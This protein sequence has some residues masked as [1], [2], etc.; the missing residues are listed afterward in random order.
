MDKSQIAPIVIAIIAALPGLFAII[1]QLRKEKTDSVKVA[2]DAAVQII[3]PLRQEVKRLQDE[4]KELQAQTDTQEKQITELQSLLREKDAQLAEKD[5]RINELEC[6]VADLR[7]RLE[8]VERRK[9]DGK[10]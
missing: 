5:A 4:I 1:A 2:Q 6:E 8:V 3:E 9:G 10:R 7:L